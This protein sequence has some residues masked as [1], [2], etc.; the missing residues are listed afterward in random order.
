MPLFNILLGFSLKGAT[1]LSQAI[2]T[3]ACL[4]HGRIERVNVSTIVE[5]CNSACRPLGMPAWA[6]AEDAL[7]DRQQNSHGTGSQH[8]TH[9]TCSCVGGA[10]ASVG[11]AMGARHPVDPGKPLIDYLTALMLTPVLLLGVSIGEIRTAIA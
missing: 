4:C 1:A 9:I 7:S 3:G 6:P 5:G 2:I 8:I 10:V 11:L